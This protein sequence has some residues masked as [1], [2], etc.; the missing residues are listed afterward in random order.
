[1]IFA[2]ASE[3]S[4]RVIKE[5]LERFACTTGLQANLPK[6]AL[7]AG[8]ISEEKREILSQILG[9]PR[10]TMPI[11]YLGVPLAGCKLGIKHYGV[12][13]EKITAR[14]CTWIA[15]LLSYAGRLQLIKSILMSLHVFWAQVFIIPVAVIEE[16]EAICRSFLWTGVALNRRMN[17]VAWSEKCLPKK[18]GG[19]GLRH[20]RA[21]NLAILFK[22][23]WEIQMKKERL[24]I[25]WVHCYYIKEANF[26][27]IKAKEGVTWVWRDIIKVRDLMK[28][29]DEM[30]QNQ[31]YSVMTGYDILR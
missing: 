16:I 19:L 18:E 21:W 23:V 12:L 7:Y 9:I 4:V 27:Y 22:M 2:K 6:S 20:L 3:A 24:R 25:K 31:L 13:V 14:I 17:L 26:L 5:V 10:G 29:H 15:R 30:L 11:K 8:G 28:N 1:M